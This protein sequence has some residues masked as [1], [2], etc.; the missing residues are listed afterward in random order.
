MR[1]IVPVMA[2]DPV[3]TRPEPR[4]LEHTFICVMPPMKQINRLMDLN[5][6]EPEMSLQNLIFGGNSKNT[7]NIKNEVNFKP[8]MKGSQINMMGDVGGGSIGQ[9]GSSSATGAGF[10]FSFNF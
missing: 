8:D 1:P 3:L 10:Q 7:G 9:S 2:V 4:M 5:E 6:I